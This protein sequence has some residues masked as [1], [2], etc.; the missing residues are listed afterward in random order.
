[1]AKQLTPALKNYTAAAAA[2]VFNYTENCAAMHF[3]A[4]QLTGFRLNRLQYIHVEKIHSC[5][6]RAQL[7]KRGMI[8]G[9]SGPRLGEIVHFVSSFFAEVHL[10]F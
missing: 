6:E 10:G 2:A 4:L 9:H 8:M 1:M 5:D 3:K 7:R